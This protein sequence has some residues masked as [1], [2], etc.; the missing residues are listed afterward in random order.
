MPNTTPKRYFYSISL[1]AILAGCGSSNSKRYSTPGGNV[2]P[3]V[4]TSVNTEE[5]DNFS[6]S[7]ESL[8][9]AVYYDREL[10]DLQLLAVELAIEDW[11]TATGINLIE[12]IGPD[13]AL[14]K[15][16]IDGLYSTLGDDR[17][18]IFL[19]PNWAVSGK[20][21]GTLATTVW[22]SPA[23][24]ADI[25]QGDI[26]FNVDHYNYS[27]GPR[28]PDDVDLRTNVDM[29]T[30]TLHELGHFLGLP[31]VPAGTD[32]DSI[33][34]PTLRVGVNAIEKPLSRG[35]VVR[36][37]EKYGCGGDAS[38]CDIEEIIDR[39]RKR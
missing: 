15:F 38:Y 31:H 19:F 5:V 22:E 9:V 32:P 2:G 17:N 28:Q 11:E 7:E 21:P 1:A 16:T 8:P 18:S 26:F 3:A 39:L 30:V 10:S 6:W 34:G 36:I 20:D 23:Q 4:G 29:K 12:L 14:D 25:S 27:E 33:M 24:S 13:D 35:D 37:Q